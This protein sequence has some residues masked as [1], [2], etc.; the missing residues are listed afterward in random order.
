MI[1]GCSIWNDIFPGVIASKVS[2]RKVRLG[3]REVI[4]YKRG[5]YYGMVRVTFS[6]LGNN[7]IIYL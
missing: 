2:S 4:F 5:Y 3:S 1:L 6:L 7:S